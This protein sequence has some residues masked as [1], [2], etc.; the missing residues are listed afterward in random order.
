MSD[1][2]VNTENTGYRA[3]GTY[4]GVIQ[5]IKQDGVCPFCPDSLRKYHTN[6]ILREGSFWLATDNLYPYAHAKHH[7]LFIHKE[8]IGHLTL[9]SREAWDELYEFLHWAIRERS[10]PG[11]TFVFRFGDTAYT[12]ASVAHLHANLVSADGTDKNREPIMTRIG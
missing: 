1:A 6:P 2:F 3:D 9:L 4:G 10:I 11:G 7:I 5:Q 8:H 12:G